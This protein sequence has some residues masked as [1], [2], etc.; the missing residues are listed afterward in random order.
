VNHPALDYQRQE[1]LVLRFGKSMWGLR[2][3]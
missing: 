3:C 1:Q 2:Q